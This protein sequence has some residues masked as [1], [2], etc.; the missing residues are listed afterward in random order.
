LYS[1]NTP[2]VERNSK[3]YYINNLLF[4]A[5]KTY[6][7]P[8]DL[9]FCSIVC[10]HDVSNNSFLSSLD[11]YMEHKYCLSQSVCLYCYVVTNIS[12]KW[13]KFVLLVATHEH[14]PSE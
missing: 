12:C 9:Y 5:D 6:V 11:M 1:S 10:T 14:R 2:T 13:S 4:L 8:T 3:S 7:T